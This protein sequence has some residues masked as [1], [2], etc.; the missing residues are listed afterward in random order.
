MLLLKS[1]VKFSGGQKFSWQDAGYIKKGVWVT[2]VAA[3][4]VS[5]KGLYSQSIIMQDFANMYV[6]GTYKVS[7]PC[8]TKF[9]QGEFWWILT[10]QIF[11]GNILMDG[12]IPLNAVLFLNNLTG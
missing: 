1:F 3:P 10:S 12:H 4:E 6:K 5:Y 9:C 2:C 8:S 7:V 11:E